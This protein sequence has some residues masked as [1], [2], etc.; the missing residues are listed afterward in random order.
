MKPVIGILADVDNERTVSVFYPYTSAI[1]KAG[2]LPLIIPFSIKEE[3]INEYVE[4]CD[5]F[6]FTGGVD[7]D[8]LYYGEEAI[9]ECG[10][11]HPY[12]DSLEFSVF[13]E[14]MRRRKPILAVCRGAELVNVALGGTLYQD[15]HSEVDTTVTHRQIEP[16]FAHSHEVNV[17][18]GT[19][20]AELFSAERVRV[21]SFHHQ[22]TRVIGRDLRTM[23][24]ADDG[25]VEALY[26][27][28]D[29]YLRAFQWHPERLYDVD[30][31]N[32]KIF[33]DFILACKSAGR[34]I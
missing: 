29:N 23:A 20:L 10:E 19:P 34:E 25:I 16:T 9:P 8:P 33:E 4:L 17:I 14:A 30:S 3:S 28:G 24:V 18:P 15:I 7:I 6:F 2:G 13:D 22:A 11:L 5:G 27:T 32:K 21:N 26:Y 31:Y 1:E 12:R